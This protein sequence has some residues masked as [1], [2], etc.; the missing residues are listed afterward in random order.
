M[1]PEIPE[2]ATRAKKDNVVE[3]S[4]EQEASKRPQSVTEKTKVLDSLQ[5]FARKQLSKSEKDAINFPGGEIRKKEI[6]LEFLSDFA[7]TARELDEVK[8]LS[9]NHSADFFHLKYSLNPKAP[10]KAIFVAECSEELNDLEGKE[11]GLEAFFESSAAQLFDRMMRA[12]KLGEGEA[13]V[14]SCFVLK[15]GERVSFE[16]PLVEEILHFRPKIVVSLG[17][18][19]TSRLL[20]ANQRLQNC[21]GQFYEKEV[22]GGDQTHSFEVMP[23]FSPAFLVEAPKL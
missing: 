3:N 19:T 12:M 21:H 2:Q 4:P 5:D 17:G 16:Q 1:E 11:L 15:D 7:P 20:G 23:L 9:S 22:T 10:L 18:A 14:S 8:K 6:G 13:L